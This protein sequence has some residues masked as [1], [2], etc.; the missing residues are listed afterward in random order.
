MHPRPHP[1]PWLPVSPGTGER[2]HRVRGRAILGSRSRQRGPALPGGRRLVA[3][4]ARRPV[5][6]C[7][8]AAASHAL[9]RRPQARGWA[10]AGLCVSGYP[11]RASCAPEC[12][13]WSRPPAPLAPAARARSWECETGTGFGIASK[14]GRPRRRSAAT[15]SA[16]GHPYGPS[17]RS[18]LPGLCVAC[19]RPRPHRDLI[20][21]SW[22]LSAARPRERPRRRSAARRRPS[23]DR[24]T[25]SWEPERGSSCCPSP[26][27]CQSRPR[28]QAG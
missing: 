4:A 18:H 12:C 2:A 28:R 3:T 22:N 1:P 14:D 15:S 6:R 10:R 5:C 27:L 21:G 11:P 23:A 17:E 20:P 8:A 13:Q 7:A 25:L 26:S 9:W 24:R 16:R 19:N